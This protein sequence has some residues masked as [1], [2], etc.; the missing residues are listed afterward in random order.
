M[1]ERHALT[2]R[3]GAVG[4]LGLLD[5]RRDP[6]PSLIW[7]KRLQPLQR[8]NVQQGSLIRNGWTISF[9]PKI[10]AMQNHYYNASSS[11]RI[12]QL[13]AA[14]VAHVDVAMHRLTT[15]LLRETV[16]ADRLVRRE[17][18]VSPDGERTH[19]SRLGKRSPQPP[20]VQFRRE[21]ELRGAPADQRQFDQPPIDIIQTPGPTR[22]RPS[23]LATILPQRPATKAADTSQM[24][25]PRRKSNRLAHQPTAQPK[26]PDNAASAFRPMHP[27]REAAPLS[28]M[29]R[30]AARPAE[31]AMQLSAG[32]RKPTPARVTPMMQHRATEQVWLK[33]PEAQGRLI[34][35]A[36]GRQFAQAVSP[37]IA[38]PQLAAAPAPMPYA[39]LQ[40][41]LPDMNRLVDEVIRR[42]DRVARDERL[43]RGV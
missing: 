12:D 36:P 31:M 38:L 22:R 5:S 15:R 29:P 3:C 41:P 19:R 1:S 25:W 7:R 37:Q 34:E 33:S 16:F 20:V 35:V 2:L 39:D 32:T 13:F 21:P 6:K 18:P 14:P 9:N 4:R 17:A 40:P 23:Q 42:I 30:S 10:V 11:T 26:T 8:F 43:R 28:S 24:K 27:A